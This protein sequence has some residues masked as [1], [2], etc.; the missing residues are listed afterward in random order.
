MS[1]KPI[2]DVEARIKMEMSY[3]GSWFFISWNKQT[4]KDLREKYITY[5]S[6]VLYNIKAFERQR[7]TKVFKHITLEDIKNIFTEGKAVTV[8]FS[9]CHSEESISLEELYEKACFYRDKK[10]DFI[11]SFGTFPNAPIKD[12]ANY[13]MYNEKKTRCAEVYKTGDYFMYRAWQRWFLG[14]ETKFVW[15]PLYLQGIDFFR[16]KEEAIEFIKPYI[17]FEEKRIDY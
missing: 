14:K 8:D 12:D 15:V 3:I 1:K 11:E 16:T 5:N 4:P 13:I 9:K 10:Q 17:Y 2:E 7:E 6:E